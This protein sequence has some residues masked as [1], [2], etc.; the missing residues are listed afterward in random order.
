MTLSR[1]RLRHFW[2][3]FH[4][5]PG[6]LLGAVFALLGLTGSV[7]CFYPELDL[8]LNPA[9]QVTASQ[10]ELPGVQRMV[11]ALHAAYPAHHGA[12][13]LE[14]PLSAGQPINARYYQ[15][16]ETAG[17][18]FA[19]LML[20]L[21]PATLK[22]TSARYWGDYAMTWIYDLH[23]SLLLER[24]GRI[25]VGVLGIVCLL[26]LFSGLYLWW[27]GRGQWLKALRLH[28]RRGTVRATYD[29]HTLAGVYGLVFLLGLAF[30]G[31]VLALPEYIRPL[32]EP[33]SPLFKPAEVHSEP[34]AGQPMIAADKAVSLAQAHFPQATL[35]W[36][37]TP[38]G[39]LGVFRVNLWQPG[40]PGFRFPRTQVWIDAYSGDVLA[41][42][43]PRDPQRQSA[44]DTFLDWQHP[45]HN[46]EAFGLP[47]RILA[48]IAGLLPTLLW[49]T[50]LMRWLHKHRARLAM[51]ARR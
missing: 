26:S 20:T 46:G 29:W 21:D 24:P 32:I 19:P 39:A 16:P 51:A 28:I 5:W 25:S 48:C 3:L 47:G 12:W 1:R 18:G 11:D 22:V 34:R 33:L 42:R 35:R 23:Y 49:V 6:L 15:P 36:V 40:E 44:G 31:V 10:P 14:M 38:K 30:T 27:P 9:Q 7:L 37:E 45:L 41:I 2:V 13:R 4:L 17:R 50:G 8:W 43:D